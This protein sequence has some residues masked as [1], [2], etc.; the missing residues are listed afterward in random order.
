MAL[1]QAKETRETGEPDA[2]K[3]ARP[4]RRGAGRK[5]GLADLARGLPLPEEA[6]THRG[7]GPCV[8]VGSAH[9][10]LD[11]T[12]DA[13]VCRHDQHSFDG[14]GQESDGAATLLYDGH[15]VRWGARLEARPPPSARPTA[16]GGPT[17][18]SDRPRC[19]SR[20]FHRLNDWIRGRG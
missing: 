4:V 9:L 6:G 2:V 14:L 8:I 16:L 18:V 5:G 20:L 12:G 17:T 13:D 10:A 7:L 3:V 11:G 15:E 1:T 19:F